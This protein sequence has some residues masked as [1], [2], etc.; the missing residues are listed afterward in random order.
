MDAATAIRQTTGSQWRIKFHQSQI[1]ESSSIFTYA[2]KREWQHAILEMAAEHHEKD[3]DV[4]RVVAYRNDEVDKLNSA[5][6]RHVYGRTA[7]PFLAGERVITHTAV[8]DP[9]D[10]TEL[11][12][13]SSRE[14]L[15]REANRTEFHHAAL[16]DGKPLHC[17]EL[18]TQTDEGE[19]ARIIRAIDPTHEGRLQIALSD[20]R[21]EA[22]TNMAKGHGQAAFDEFWELCDA[23]AQLQPYWCLTCHKAQGSQFRHVFV[24]SHDLDTAGGGFAERR[25][26]WYT[27]FTRA[28]QA[29]HLIADPEVAKL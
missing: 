2:D 25:R 21:K 22:T 20:L 27:A 17:W 15:I 7:A 16:A 5:I 12:Y 14:L 10:R 13:G 11:V 26:L 9:F 28:Q 1:G 6:R 4:F 29:V 8:K 3:P 18:I 19:P 23:F 24:Q